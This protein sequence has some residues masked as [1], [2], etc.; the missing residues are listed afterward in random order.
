MRDE[1]VYRKDENGEF[2]PFGVRTGQNYLPDGIWYVH[3]TEYSH[4]WTDMRYIQGLQRIGNAEIPELPK[5]AGIYSMAEKIGHSKKVQ[6]TFFSDK[7][8]TLTELINVILSE[9]YNT[10]VDGQGN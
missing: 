3:H 6:D 10:T 2:I 5:I 7:G 4:G 1:N 9:L 8:H